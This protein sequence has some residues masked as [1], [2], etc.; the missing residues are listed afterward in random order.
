MPKAWVRD[1][2]PQKRDEGVLRSVSGA[3]IPVNFKISFGKFPTSENLPTRMRS[4][5]RICLVLFS[6]MLISQISFALPAQQEVLWKQNVDPDTEW[7]K[8]MISVYKPYLE[9]LHKAL[10]PLKELKFEDGLSENEIKEKTKQA[11]IAYLEGIKSI[12]PPERFEAY[13]SNLVKLVLEK[14]K[15]SPNEELIKTLIEEG[16]QE[17]ILILTQRKVPEKVLKVFTTARKSN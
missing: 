10:L 6:L 5:K 16:R 12:K 7:G 9:D 3:G 1:R 2:V 13:H 8:W 4:M 14:M 15:Q 11:Q 17:M